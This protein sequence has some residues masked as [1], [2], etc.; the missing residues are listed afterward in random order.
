MS[1]DKSSIRDS[2]YWGQFH[3]IFKLFSEIV[4]EQIKHPFLINL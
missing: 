1:N 2:L 4:G 3:G